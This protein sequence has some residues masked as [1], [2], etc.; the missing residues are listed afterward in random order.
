MGMILKAEWKKLP[1]VT[2]EGKWFYRAI[3]NGVEVT[4]LQSMFSALW[5][6][7]WKG[8]ITD[9]FKTAKQAMTIAE[10]RI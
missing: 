8:T 6:V 1:S 4:V 3:I 7:T 9:E 5:T 2:R 10:N